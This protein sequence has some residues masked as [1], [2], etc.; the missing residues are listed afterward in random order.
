MNK[1]ENGADAVMDV[2]RRSGCDDIRIVQVIDH[3]S[4]VI[5]WYGIEERTGRVFDLIAYPVPQAR[6]ITP[7]SL[8][9]AIFAAYLD[10][11][12]AGRPKWWI[13]MQGRKGR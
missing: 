5:G 8:A 10:W 11:I 3:E 9:R 2:L 7:E 12:E 4:G 1:A 6:K 13:K